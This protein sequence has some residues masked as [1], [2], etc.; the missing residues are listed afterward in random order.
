[1][2][3][4]SFLSDAEDEYQQALAWYQERSLRAA[5]G[6][7]AAV[8]VAL[9]RIADAPEMGALCDDRHRFCILRKYPF[10][11]IYRIEAGDILVVAVAHSRR[12]PFYWHSRD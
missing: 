11:I 2:A 6:F 3:K 4:V 7:E 5:A 9:R 10:S 8:D 12:S 1:V